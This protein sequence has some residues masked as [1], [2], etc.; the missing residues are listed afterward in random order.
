VFSQK[1]VDILRQILLTCLAGPQ[2]HMLY[3]LDIR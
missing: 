3:L 1:R 2:D